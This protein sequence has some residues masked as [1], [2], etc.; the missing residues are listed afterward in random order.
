M[1]NV[2]LY[3]SEGD[4][5]Q[6]GGK[7]YYK[8][9][10]FIPYPITISFGKPLPSTSTTFQVRQSVMDLGANAFQYRLVDKMTLSEAFYKGARKHPFRKCIADSSGKKLNYGMTLVS[11]V[12]LANQLKEKLGDHKNI[13]IML[14]PSV[15]GV[16]ANIAVSFLNKVPVNLNYTTSKETIEVIL[17]QCEMKYVIT[18]R[19]FL[20]KAKIDVPGQL[21]LMEDIVK[22]ILRADKLKAFIQSF[23]V[24]IFMANRIIFKKSHQRSLRN[25]ATIMFTSGSTGVPKG[26]MLTHFNIISNL[27]GL[28]QVFHMRDDEVFMGVLPFFHSFGFTA[29]LWLPLISG[30]SAV[31]HYNPLDAKMIGRLVEKH[32]ATVLKA[33]PTFLNAYTRRCEPEQFKSLRIVVVGAEKLKAQVAYAFRDKFNIEPM[34]GY[35]CTELSPIVSLNLPDYT[36][37]GGRQ[38]AHK[39]GSIGQPLPGITIKIVNQDTFEPVTEGEKGMLLVKGPNVMKGYLNREDLTKEVI[40][41]GWYITGDI[42][43]IDEDGFIVITDR[44]SRFSKIGGEMIPHIKVEE[45]IHE[46]LNTSEQK[47]VVASVPDERKGEKLVVICLS[48]VDVPSLVDGLKQSGLPNLWIPSDDCFH[49]VESIPLLGSGKIDLGKIKKIAKDVFGGAD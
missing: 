10:K 13:G 19:A 39:F 29:T 8:I 17:K 36:G 27:E 21:I 15:A 46:I 1:R 24:P 47:C 16:L 23:I 25:L 42:A 4:R 37:P 3:L 38:K 49:K 44:L 40:K 45:A 5:D 28:Y 14:P 26:V 30:T 18:S 12:A 34:E 2:Y 35:G 33:T 7:Y 22:G 43:M 6:L 32:T 31:Y 9:P 48:D 11:A 41:D 20:E